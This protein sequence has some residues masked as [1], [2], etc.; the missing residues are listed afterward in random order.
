MKVYNRNLILAMTT[1]FFNLSLMAQVNSSGNLSSFVQQELVSLTIAKNA[2][3]LTNLFKR[4]SPHMVRYGAGSATILGPH[5]NFFSARHVNPD[6]PIED[7]TSTSGQRFQVLTEEFADT[8]GSSMRTFAAPQDSI[9]RMVF[10]GRVLYN[11]EIDY[12]HVLKKTYPTNLD[13]RIGRLGGLLVPSDGFIPDEQTLNKSFSATFSLPQLRIRE[14]IPGEKI[15]MMGFPRLLNSQLAWSEGIVLGE[16]AARTIIENTSNKKK[17]KAVFQPHSE[18]I[19]K[20]LASA[21]FSGGAA[22]SLTGEYLGILVRSS[23][24]EGYVR[25]IRAK[26]ALE[27]F[28]FAL[29]SLPTPRQKNLAVD[30]QNLFRYN[31]P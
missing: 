5:G 4:L 6:G 8:S 29:Q 18:F 31:Y 3:P 15:L 24:S 26:Y 9:S 11:P 21:G 2:N 14:A 12:D 28:K 7:R 23:T 27:K 13:Y 17:K 16:T 30:A 22:F 10:P 1:V 20:G 25:V 19:V